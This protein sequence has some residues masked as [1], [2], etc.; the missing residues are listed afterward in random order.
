MKSHGR[1]WKTALV[2]TLLMGSSLW[3]GVKNGKVTGPEVDSIK[4][5]VVVNND[6]YKIYRSSALGKS[7]LKDV[8][9]HLQKNNLPLPK[10]VI[11]MNKGGYAFPFY[12]ALD[13]YKASIDK[14]SKDFWPFEFVH[15]F[16]KDRTYIYGQN[17]YNSDEDIDS[18]SVLGSEARKYFPLGDDGVDGGVDAVKRVMDI[19]LDPARQPVLFHCH[20]GRHRTGMVAMMVRYLQGGWW[21]DGVY[22]REKGIDMNPAQYEYLEYNHLMFREENLEFVE[23]FQ[24]DPY[25][26]DL[27][28][29]YG[30]LLQEKT[31]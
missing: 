17:P 12:F 10:T 27:K 9:K 4:F 2:S 19:V 14:K 21:T 5:G 7:G 8:K 26:L 13:E 29:K 15:P 31:K 28:E 1:L 11:Y 23:E 22:K 24:H 30:P 18:K 25:F 6:T 3:A 20:G 16:G